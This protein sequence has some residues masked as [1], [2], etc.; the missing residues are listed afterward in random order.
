MRKYNNVI[1]ILFFVC[2]IIFIVMLC[3]IAGINDNRSSAEEAAAG[4]SVSD[5][6]SF[7]ENLSDRGKHYGSNLSL[8][9]GQ[10]D[11]FVISS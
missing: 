10:D 8:D 9:V 5:R 6:K 7:D 4:D 2:V 11:D 1:F 3:V